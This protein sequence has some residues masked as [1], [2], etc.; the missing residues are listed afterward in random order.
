MRAIV[1]DKAV[2]EWDGGWKTASVRAGVDPADVTAGAGFAIA[3]DPGVPVTPEPP[4]DALEL[5]RT[6]IDPLGIRRLEVRET[7]EQA[8][9]D[10]QRWAASR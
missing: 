10:L 8:A 1:T 2:L 3:I 6:E 9:A 5:L 4:A 7:R